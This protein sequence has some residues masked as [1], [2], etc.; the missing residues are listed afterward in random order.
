MR[1][2]LDEVTEHERQRLIDRLQ[3]SSAALAA[4]VKRGVNTSANGEARW[5][6]HDV[7]AHIAVL[8]KYYGMLTYQVG[9]GKVSEVDLL[10][11]VRARDIAGE[12]LGRLSDSELLAVID[13]DHQRT[14]A[15][16]KSADAAAMHR[17]AELYPGFSMS[18]FEL[19]SLGLC[20]HL[21]IHLAQ[22]EATRQP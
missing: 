16:L 21:E 9:S 19:A 5:S 15:F 1:A 8:S 13:G 12:Q 7:L 22:L 11:A 2:F 18:A 10:Q 14:I 6:G 17:R 3:A 20:A 4:Q